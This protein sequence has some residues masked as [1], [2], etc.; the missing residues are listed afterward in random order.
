MNTIMHF[1]QFADIIAYALRHRLHGWSDNANSN[2]YVDA[3]WQR[4][5]S[6]FL[7]S[8][9]AERQPT[10]E[11]HTFFSSITETMTCRIGFSTLFFFVVVGF[12]PNSFFF[13]RERT[14]TRVLP[15]GGGATGAIPARNVQFGWTSSGGQ[16][17]AASTVQ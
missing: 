14:Q 9:I 11:S 6:A 8:N 4:K 15:K 17:L 10:T 13:R 5:V 3:I 16:H 7:Q 12:Y 1:M 2:R